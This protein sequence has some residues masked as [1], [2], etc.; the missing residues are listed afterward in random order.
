MEAYCRCVKCGNNH[1][2]TSCT[3]TKTEPPKCANCGEDHPANYRGCKIHTD[4]QNK[5]ASRSIHRT[6]SSQIIQPNQKSDNLKPRSLNRPYSSVLKDFPKINAFPP[7][8]ST[9]QQ[10]TPFNTNNLIETIVNL[11][12]QILTPVI[13]Q[14]KDFL[15]NNILPNLI[16]V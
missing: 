10:Q 4:L 9:H 6:P 5:N 1:I 13:T 16:N 15:I 2:H 8:S 12:K 7:Q 11:I 14:I 3:K